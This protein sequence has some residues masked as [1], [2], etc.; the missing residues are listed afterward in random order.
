[1]GVHA[2]EE[3]RF[4]SVHELADDHFALVLDVHGPGVGA[5]PDLGV[6]VII[7][8]KVQPVAEP[9]AAGV[10]CDAGSD[11]SMNRKPFF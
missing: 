4:F 10:E 9:V 1:M 6:V 2:F 8:E 5:V 3:G 7:F 11:D